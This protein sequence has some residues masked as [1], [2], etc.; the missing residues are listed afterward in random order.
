MD[1]D[2][3][4]ETEPDKRTSAM[5]KNEAAKMVE[6]YDKAIVASGPFMAFDP[7]ATL[8]RAAPSIWAETSPLLRA[9]PL[10]THPKEAA[11]RS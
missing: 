11:S 2:P 8:I 10:S 9:I 7:A 5:K 3:S 4:E 6:P 1:Y